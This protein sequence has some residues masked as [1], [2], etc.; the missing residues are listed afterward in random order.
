MTALGGQGGDGSRPLLLVG[1]G[2][3]GSWQAFMGEAGRGGPPVC[4]QQ[5]TARWP[6]LEEP[7]DPTATVCKTQ[8]SGTL[9]TQTFKNEKGEA[10]YSR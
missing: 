2:Q 8:V 3:W 9:V 4:G 10:T 7:P 6:G 5:Q 1:D